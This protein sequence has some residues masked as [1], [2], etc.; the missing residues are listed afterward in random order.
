[1][2]ACDEAHQRPAVCAAYA[3]IRER[4]LADGTDPST[5]SA[6]ERAPQFAQPNRRSSSPLRSNRPI[7]ETRSTPIPGVFETDGRGR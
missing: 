7:A 1:V 6:H 5:I 4:R 3:Q 2:L